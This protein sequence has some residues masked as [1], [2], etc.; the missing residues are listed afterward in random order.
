MKN[1]SRLR[2]GLLLACALA[3]HGCSASNPTSGDGPEQPHAEVDSGTGA[4]ETVD[5]GPGDAGDAD[6]GN[7]DPGDAGEVDAGGGDDGGTEGSD[8]G[9]EPDPWDGSA[10]PLEERTDWVDPGPYSTC[11]FKP[12]TGTRPTTCDDPA[13]FDVSTC[14]PG[15]FTGLES[16][17]IY[18][19]QL[20]SSGGVPSL[21][22][23]LDFPADGGTGTFHDTL[24]T[25]SQLGEAGFF[26]TYR[27][28]LPDAGVREY[29]MAGCGTPEP[30]H[31]T[32]CYGQCNDGKVSARGTFVAAR[33]TWARGEQE[34]SGG[35]HLLSETFVSLGTPVDIYVT[36]QHAYVVSIGSTGRPGGGLTVYDVHD[37]SHPLLT[38]TITFPMDTYWNGVWAKDDALY[39]ASALS[40]VIV[41]DIHDPAHPAFVRNLPSGPPLD[42]HTVFVE[43]NRLYAM[44]PFPDGETLLFDISQPLSPV[45][46]NR[47][48]INAPYGFSSPHDAF[49]YEGRLYV[50]LM[51]SGYYVLDVRDPE[52]VQTL[53][54]YS[55]DPEY[56]HANAVGT[57]GG[58]TI[59]FEGGEQAGAHLRI[60]DVT[61]PANITLIGEY[62][63]SP[64]LSIH[65]MVL[66][67]KRLYIAYY[68]QGLRVLDVSIP[69]HPRE[70]AYFNTYREGDPFRTTSFFDGAIGVRAPGDGHVY[71]VDL[72]RGLLIFNEP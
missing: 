62:S 8:A 44:S 47:I 15:A 22:G 18:D 10:T 30:G 66:K 55:F 58:R 31:I 68:Q 45:L 27:R 3:L 57:F 60:L 41:F 40:G 16:H 39:V 59:A 52:H 23:T 20:R 49:A 24:L 48:H 7:L 70:V 4:P 2:R 32:G 17:G 5:A 14:A 54:S 35:I 56:S 36:R 37:P 43:G 6:A 26:A 61:D 11:T 63:R 28:V 19:A 29:V 9:T 71:V 69:P 53:G 67:G 25:R 51:E 13:L 38:D 64:L 65:N 21:G 42:V 34:S 46:L 33:R 50:N 1:G 12:A 72:A